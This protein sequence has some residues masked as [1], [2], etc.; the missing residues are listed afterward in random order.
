MKVLAALL[1]YDY[2][3]RDRGESME[4]L[5]FFPALQ[6]TASSVTPFWLEENGYP[7]DLDGLQERIIAFA[8]EAKPDL[9]YLMLMRNEITLETIKQLSNQYM[10]VNWFGDD[11]WRFDSFTRFVAPVL[12]WSITT[13]KYSL[14]KYR[15][16]GIKQVILSQ[17]ATGC[18]IEDVDF[19]SI[20]YR[21]DVSFVG[22]KNSTREWIIDQ[23]AKRKIAV[24]CFGSDWPEGR[25]SAQEMKDIFLKS[26]VN[27]NLSNSVQ[28]DRAY[29]DFIRQ[30]LFR[31]IFEPRGKSTIRY[32][33][34]IKRGLNAVLA[35]QPKQNEQVK[36][37]N[38]EIS[39]CGG[40]Q[41]SQYALGLED[42]FIPGKE[43]ALFSTIDELER[44]I[45]YYLG[46]EDQRKRI[47]EEG[48]KRAQ[49]HTYE[50]RFREI[51]KEMRI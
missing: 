45:V 33:K 36:A 30:R 16:L 35:H 22:G 48:Y 8:A 38:F 24:T 39:G 19:T 15:D 1:K 5:Y 47:A 21:F 17:W 46:H 32:L 10:T 28:G 31:S 12:S 18:Y 43:I 14:E 44:Q 23:L 25:V 49:G 40:F 20:N 4:K 51:F 26:K 34:E 6:K 9:I 2:G 29:H 27:L 42:Y 37:R 50:N 13:D 11:P 7:N 41:L 3:K